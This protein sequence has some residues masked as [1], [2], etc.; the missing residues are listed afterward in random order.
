LQTDSDH[1]I[2][3][4]SG[5]TVWKDIFFP[6]APPKTTG[7]GNPSLVSWNGN[8][9]GYSFAVGD[10]HDFDPQEFS[11][12]GQQ[13]SAATWH[14]HF[15]SRTDVAA[16]R[17][18]NFQVEYSQANRSDVYPAP[19]TVSMEIEIPADTPVNTHF[20]VDIGAFISSNIAS[21]MYSRL[22]RIAAVTGA[23][24]ADDPVITG[25]HYHYQI[26]TIGSREIFA[27]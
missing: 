2:E 5:L 7:V 21:Q 1:T 4:H 17:Y 14:L 23:E 10:A 24:P 8:L 15:I 20:A 13:G 19:T 9:R 25:L 12:D 27:K 22:T 3:L 26:D 18:V 6:M 11:H 16:L